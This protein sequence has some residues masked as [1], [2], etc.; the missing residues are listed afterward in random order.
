MSDESNKKFFALI[1][2]GQNN[3]PLKSDSQESRE[4]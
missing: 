3:N 4:I 2:R 1:M